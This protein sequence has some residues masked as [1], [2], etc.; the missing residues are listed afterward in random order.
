M[1]SYSREGGRCREAGIQKRRCGTQGGRRSAGARGVE[2]LPASRLRLPGNA[3]ILSSDKV[4]VFFSA[5]LLHRPDVIKAGMRRLL[6]NVG[7][8]GASNAKPIVAAWSERSLFEIVLNARESAGVFVKG[9]RPDVRKT[10]EPQVARK[11]LGLNL[12]RG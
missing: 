12:L 1:V 11:H 2:T 7:S 4:A 10:G 6:H 9:D 8:A 5:G 3:A